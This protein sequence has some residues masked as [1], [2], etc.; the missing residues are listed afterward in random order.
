MKY[1]IALSSLL[2][3]IFSFPVWS[4]EGAKPKDNHAHEKG[5]NAHEHD[6][7][8]EK[9]ESHGHAHQEDEKDDHGHAT[10]ESEHGEEEG[11][12][13]V[14]PDKGIIE[15]SAENGIRLSPEALKNFEIRTL[16]ITGNGPWPIP[17]SARLLAGEEVNIYRVRDG[18]FK[19]IDFTQAK[20]TPENMTINSTD[21]KSGD[22][23]VISGIGFLRIAELAA[24]GGAPEGH[25]H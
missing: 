6:V 10:K 15:A 5:E 9:K 4:Q 1:L 18:A 23:I 11:A 14:G 22:E 3:I 25:S 21:L 20:K 17:T 19:R 7:K 2:A 13:N 12:S 8:A 16:K 24:F